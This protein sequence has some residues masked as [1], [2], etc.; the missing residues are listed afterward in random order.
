[1][2]TRK[3]PE[4]PIHE[5]SIH[6][7]HVA[8]NGWDPP[9]FIARTQNVEG[10]E[11]RTG[12]AKCRP[13]HHLEEA[14]LKTRRLEGKACLS[15]FLQRQTAASTSTGVVSTADSARGTSVTDKSCRVA[16]PAWPQSACPMTYGAPDSGPLSA[17][18]AKA[19][20]ASAASAGE[21]LDLPRPSGAAHR[22]HH[23]GKGLVL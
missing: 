11:A 8:E 4:E 17:A 21:P 15:C 9:S 5:E 19:A 22:P 20:M 16:G 2:L 13:K 18:I 14:R 10:L 12:T 1:M 7:M 3:K 23:P 6:I